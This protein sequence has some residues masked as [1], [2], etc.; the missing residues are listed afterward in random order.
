M[1][2]GSERQ[3]Q[4]SP[5]VKRHAIFASVA[6]GAILAIAL[7]LRLWGAFS[8]LPYVYHPDEPVN[9]DVIQTMLVNADPNPHFFHYPSLFLYVNALAALLYF[10]VRA[11]ITGQPWELL[12]P[13]S[14]AMGSTYALSADAVALYRSLSICGGVL[15]VLLVYRIG[16][17]GG[18]R[19]AG[20]LAAALA[21]ISPLL[22][23]DCR[24]A[25]PDSY[26]IVFV[27]LAV[28]AS[29]GI[30][31]S[32]RWILYIAAGAAVGAAAATKYNGVLACVCVIAAHCVRFG[33]ASKYWPRIL[34]AG[35]SS[36][37]IFFACS[38]FSVLDYATSV[39]DLTH[40]FEHY[41]GSHQGME[42]NTVVWYLYRLWSATGIA[43]LLAVCELVRVWR[44]RA[45]VS[46]VLG[47]FVMTYLVFIARFN[48]HNDRT[49]LP[50]VPCI[51]LLAASFVAYL[52]SP[53]S[54]LRR[55][56]SSLRRSAVVAVGVGMVISPLRLSIAEARVLSTIDS[57]ATAREWINS[58]LPPTSQVAVESYAPFV[59]PMR[60]HI[61]Q[62]ERA[63]DHTTDWY[64]D[65]NIDY[66]VLSQGTFGRYFD[67]ADRYP[68]EVARYLRLMD[69]LNLVR[70]FEDGG[71]R[72]LVYQT[73]KG[74][75]PRSEPRDLVNP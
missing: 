10:S 43:S 14:I 38:P 33:L 54:P 51:L 59:S 26:V 27:L 13:L 70:R 35:V 65:H 3:Y 46:I 41:S 12:P 73:R 32:G 22:V 20:L 2:N 25:T 7:A 28:V 42:G 60:F 69:S 53:Q 17:R 68:N 44:N 74:G 48:V 21:A 15:S 50:V 71:Y 8:D 5:D 19:K 23:A 34:V 16:R 24:H 67:N 52:V 31:R 39:A 29:L 45:P 40:E 64:A 63:I 72:V 11:L 57:R 6:L 36:A 4:V 47:C 66:V 49:L 58:E 37:V 55:V 18:G 1:E 62:A 30:A 56:S 75:V 9:I 61:I